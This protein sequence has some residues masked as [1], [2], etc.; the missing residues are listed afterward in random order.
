MKIWN[1]FNKSEKML[2]QAFG[3]LPFYKDYIA[4]LYGKES[5][6]W[7]DWL[8]N[9]FG[10]KQK[11]PEGKWYF[12]FKNSKKSKLILG[13]MK[14]SSDGMRE[15]PFTLFACCKNPNSGLLLKIWEELEFVWD[16]ILSIDNIT[17]FYSFLKK[18]ELIINKRLLQ[19]ENE[20]DRKIEEFKKSTI[21]WP[22]ILITYDKNNY[23]ISEC[24][25]YNE[26]IM[27]W[28]KNEL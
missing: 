6:G 21:Q 23:F 25:D 27:K 14:A 15:F 22:R 26:L 5:I 17:N 12:I 9:T 1:I 24:H 13:I 7:R 16:E 18:K 2:L 4:V 8:V 19:S 28:D 10:N 11:P 3:K 20:W